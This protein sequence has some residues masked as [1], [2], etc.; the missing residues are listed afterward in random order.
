MQMCSVAFRTHYICILEE[1]IGINNKTSY[2]NFAVTISNM[3][4]TC[5]MLNIYSGSR[6]KTK[7]MLSWYL[8]KS[9]GYIYITPHTCGLWERMVESV[10]QMFHYFSEDINPIHFLIGS[11]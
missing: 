8:E 3:V 2:N 7:L 9:N 10:K 5:K 11:A 4:A 6:A 1:K